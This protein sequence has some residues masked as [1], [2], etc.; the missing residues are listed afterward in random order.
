MPSV[1]VALLNEGTNAWRPVLARRW[2][3]SR[4][5][6]LGVVPSQEEWQFLPGQTVEC[7]LRVLS[8]GEALVAVRLAQ[9]A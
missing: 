4:Y 8:G 7:E 9:G 2:A 3:N 5:E 6:L 1:Y